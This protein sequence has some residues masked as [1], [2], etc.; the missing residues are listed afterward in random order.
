MRQWPSILRLSYPSF[1]T[2][3][4]PQ[5]LLSLILRGFRNQQTSDPACPHDHFCE[6]FSGTG[7]LTREC[8]RMGLRGSAFD[9]VYEAEEHNLCSSKGVRLVLDCISGLCWH[10]LLWIACECSSFTVLCRAV[11]CRHEGNGLL[12]RHITKLRGHRKPIDVC[13][14]PLLLHQLRLASVCS[15]GAAAEF[16]LAILRAY[17]WSFPL[18]WNCGIQSVPW[19]LWFSQC[20]TFVPFHHLEEHS[21]LGVEQAQM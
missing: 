4:L 8:L 13:Q 7:N 12:G 11:S 16:L 17:L 2:W 3:D 14:Q 10:G 21:A 1:R 19:K 20:Q 6:A 5:M 9:W 15:A 18:H